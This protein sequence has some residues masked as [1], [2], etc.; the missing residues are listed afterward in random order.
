MVKY[1][2]VGATVDATQVSE[3]NFDDLAAKHGAATYQGLEGQRYM[4]LEGPGGSTRADIGGFV[5]TKEGEAGA[6]G[7]R[8]A[9]SFHATYERP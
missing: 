9:E 1:V 2:Q 8:D 5:V 6:V 3:S 4:I 7:F